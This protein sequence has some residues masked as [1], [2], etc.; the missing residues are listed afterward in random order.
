M[1]AFIT[2]PIEYGPEYIAQATVDG[3]DPDNVY[4][5]TLPGKTYPV[6]RIGSRWQYHTTWIEARDFLLEA[7]KK[8]HMDRWGCHAEDDRLRQHLYAINQL[9]EPKT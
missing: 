1:I 7:A 3:F 2:N 6:S 9:E 4:L 8:D 5:E